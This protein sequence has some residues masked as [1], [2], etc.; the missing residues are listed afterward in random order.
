MEFKEQQHIVSIQISVSP[1]SQNTAKHC[2]Q[3]TLTM[4][5]TQTV[6]SKYGS[7]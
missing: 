3:N 2:V 4:Y 6:I 7:F 5:T 1:L